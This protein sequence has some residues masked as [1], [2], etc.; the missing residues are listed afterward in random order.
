MAAADGTSRTSRAVA[1]RGEATGVVSSIED[2]ARRAGVSVATVSRALRGLPNVAPSTRDRVTR[3]AEELH[4]VADPNASRL[5]ARRTATLGLVVPMLGQWYYAQLFAGA[6]GAA[7][8][9]GHDI[10]PFV[11]GGDVVRDRFL[12]AMP[13]R[14]RV[15]GLVVADVQFDDAQWERLRSAGV[16][17]VTIGTIQSQLPSLSIDNR[18]AARMA[19]DHLCELGHRRIGL[20]SSL[21]DDPFH[22]T[23]PVQRELGAADALEAAGG[24]LDASL[25]V[26]GGFSHQGGAEAMEQL[27]ARPHPPTAV[28]ALS[29]EMAIGALHAARAGGLRVPEDLSVVGFDDNDVSR[30]LGLTTV[31]QRV[32]EHGERAVARLLQE[33][34]DGRGAAEHTTLATQLVLRGTTAPPGSGP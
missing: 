32:V 23:A 14:K 19:V 3:A 18:A 27:L 34:V 20:I 4:Y 8:A 11:I 9:A 29:D 16:P 12:A 17:I 24:E 21:R 7:V 6:E 33:I 2:V 22:F 31:R 1:T 5:A 30:Y 15:D 10:L 13:F 28:F 26:P 25:V